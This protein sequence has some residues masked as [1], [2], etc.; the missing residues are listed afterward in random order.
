MKTV[1]LVARQ[2]SFAA[3]AR[4]LNLDPSS[5]SRTVANTESELGLRLFQRS[6]RAL[7]TTEAGAIYLAQITPL[8][9]EFDRAQE[10]AQQAVRGPTGVLKMTTSVSFAQICVVPHLKEFLDLNPAISLELLPTDANVDLIGE[11]IDLAIRLAPAPE[12]DL[13]SSKLRSTRYIVCASPDY[14]ARHVPIDRPVDL[15]KHDCLCFALPGYR[16]LWRFRQSDGVV[17]E[18]AI[19]GRLVVSNA[20]ALHRTALDGLGPSLLPDWLVGPDIARGDLLDLLPEFECTATGFDTAAWALYPSRSYL[21][22]K[23]R[24]MIDFLRQKLA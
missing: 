22:Q 10:A 24:A 18:V 4:V 20:L 14:A 11:K 19:H 13:I 16:T 15:Q 3:A 9:E 17:T 2:G 23:V 7:T 6:T 1:A 12:G 8:L 5:V 21:P